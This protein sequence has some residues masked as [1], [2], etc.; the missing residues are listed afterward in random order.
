MFLLLNVECKS[1]LTIYLSN[2]LDNL[3][4]KLNIVSYALM[5]HCVNKAHPNPS[6]KDIT[7]LITMRLTLKMLCIRVIF[8]EISIDEFIETIVNT[9]QYSSLAYCCRN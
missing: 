7:D 6:A 5:E 2:E 8:A 3:T 4:D 1:T 9:A